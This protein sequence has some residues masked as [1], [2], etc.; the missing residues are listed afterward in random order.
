[1]LAALTLAPALSAPLPQNAVLAN[2]IAGKIVKFESRNPKNFEDIVAKAQ[3]PAVTLDALLFVPTG[4]APRAAVIVVPG[5]GGVQESHLLQANA[6]TSAGVVT[7]LVDPFTGRGVTDTIAD[8][9]AFSFAASAYDVLAA[10]QYLAEQGLDT[11][12]IGAV[13]YSR[14][15]IAVLMAA[16]RQLAPVV[17][18]EGKALGAVLGG[19]PW[20]GFQFENA[21]TAPTAVRFALAD[22]DNWVSPV[23]CQ[24]WAAAMRG[25]NPN[26]SVRLFENADHSFGY[27]MPMR[28]IPN[29]ITAYNAPI[30]YLDDQGR[31]LDLYSGAALA[32][33]SDRDIL[34]VAA[35]WVGRGVRLGTKPGQTDAFMADM[36]D[37]FRKTLAP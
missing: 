32:G 7:L 1:L 19:W 36:V 9:S 33:K 3:A 26:V 14:G 27:N 18:G 23:Q 31:Y 22:R 17:L 13:G 16:S 10:A 35:P 11:A 20:C 8:Q 6:L 4:P 15:G 34:M 25:S 12:R 2:G 37:F 24:G 21:R 29:A 30:L 5:S 28:E